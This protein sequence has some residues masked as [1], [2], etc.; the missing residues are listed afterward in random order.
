MSRKNRAPK[1]TFYPDPK[2]GSLI[3]SKFINFVMY[4][5]N[6]TAAEKII[7]TAFK[8]IKDKA[9]EDPIKI[10]NDAINNIH[11]TLKLD[12]EELVVQLIKFLKK[13]KQRDHKL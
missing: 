2:Y 9:K 13:L 6:K 4:D 7:Y 5:G 3:L 8:Q 10:F 11:P 1:R 12:L